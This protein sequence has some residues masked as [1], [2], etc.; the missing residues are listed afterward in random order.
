MSR[1]H[2]ASQEERLVK[3]ESY[4]QLLQPKATLLQQMRGMPAENCRWYKCEFVLLPLSLLSVLL[5]YFE[6]LRMEEGL[7]FQTD[8]ILGAAFRSDTDKMKDQ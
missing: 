3:I 8:S 1:L 6:H 5:F 4:E 7:N 2:A